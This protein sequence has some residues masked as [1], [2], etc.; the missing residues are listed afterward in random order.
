MLNNAIIDCVTPVEVAG[1]VEPISLRQPIVR[2]IKG[3][4]VGMGLTSPCQINHLY[5]IMY[6]TLRQSAI[7]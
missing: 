4:D 7:G 5:N 6:N 3:F 2:R 1:Q